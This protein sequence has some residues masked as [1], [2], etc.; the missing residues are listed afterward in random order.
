MIFSK[1]T[2]DII[3]YYPQH[4]NRSKDGTN[5]F[6]EPLIEICEQNGLT[7]LLVEEPDNKTTFPRNKKAVRFGFWLYIIICLRKLLSD[8]LFIDNVQKEI[9]IGKIIAFFSFNFFK[10]KTYITISNSMIGLLIGF[11]KKA[12]VFDLQHG[13]I[14]SWHPGYF[15]SNGELNNF[16]KHERIGF[17]ITGKG[18]KESFQIKNNTISNKKVVVIGSN[19]FENIK[20]EKIFDKREILYTLL[21]TRDDTDEFLLEQKTKLQL[22]LSDFQKKALENNLTILLKHHPRFN[23]VIDISDILEQFSFVKITETNFEELSKTVFLHITK[24]STSAFELASL[25]IPTVFLSN[26]MGKKIF[27]EEYKYPNYN[28]PFES[29]IELYANCNPKFFELVDE[30]KK[31]SSHF[32]EPFNEALFLELVKPSKNN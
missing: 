10:A 31:W 24:Y 28:L 17:L 2:Y 12:N 8:R 14:Y 25:S 21:F 6:F 11:D 29:W 1:K 26:E 9:F 22:F 27:Q 5:P 15:Q 30:T 19:Q 16:L 4:F 18:Y 20:K 23:N 3:F 7:Y 32:Y 13:I